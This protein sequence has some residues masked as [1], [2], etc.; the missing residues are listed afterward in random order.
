MVASTLIEEEQISTHPNQ[1]VTST[2]LKKLL[3]QMG[4]KTLTNQE[5]IQLLNQDRQRYNKTHNL[6]TSHFYKSH[7]LLLKI[8][9]KMHFHQSCNK[10]QGSIQC[11]FL[12]VAQQDHQITKTLW[13]NTKKLTNQKLLKWEL[14]EK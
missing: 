2:N 10:N 5:Y 11:K 3:S 8:Q 9:Q 14:K 12:V 4:I 13:K 1:K 7:Q 6:A